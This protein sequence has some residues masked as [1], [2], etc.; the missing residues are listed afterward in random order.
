M[1]CKKY[2]NGPAISLMTKKARIAN[3][4]KVNTYYLNGQDKTTSYR[5]LVT[6]ERLVM[7]QSGL[8]EYTEVSSWTWAVPSYSGTWK[9]I[10]DKEDVEMVSDNAKIGTQT[11]RI[12]RLKNKQ[13]WMKIQ[14]TP[15]SLIEYH[16]I[17]YT[18]E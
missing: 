17:P 4:W 11:Y 1:S 5:S 12:T 10:N 9:F 2:E 16:Y 6:R 3:S 7:Y 13:L 14:L 8:F 15:D 18:E